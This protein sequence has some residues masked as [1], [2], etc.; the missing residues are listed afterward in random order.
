MMDKAQTERFVEPLKR[1]G[2]SAGNGRLRE[3]LRWDEPSYLAIKSA[4]IHEGIVAPGRGRGGSVVAAE[5]RGNGF[6]Y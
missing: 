6:S 3:A 1:L 4:L 5:V 2:G